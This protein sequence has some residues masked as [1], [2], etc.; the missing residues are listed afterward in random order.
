[1]S[2]AVVKKEVDSV[3]R[4]LSAGQLAAMIAMRGTE[5]VNGFKWVWTTSDAEDGD[6]ETKEVVVEFEVEQHLSDSKREE[7][8]WWSIMQ[9]S[10]SSMSLTLLYVLSL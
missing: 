8:C 4:M 6:G 5:E 10:A 1:M 7:S 2:S 9:Q 3:R